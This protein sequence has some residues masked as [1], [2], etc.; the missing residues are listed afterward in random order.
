[1]YF[2]SKKVIKKN[3]E[4]SKELEFSIPSQ[5]EKYSFISIFFAVLFE[6]NSFLRF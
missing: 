4:V 1:M 2:K 5:T 6:I 3:G